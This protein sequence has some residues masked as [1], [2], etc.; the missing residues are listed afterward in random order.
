MV[1]RVKEYIEKT[2]H[3][4]NSDK[5]KKYILRGRRNARYLAKIISN[6]KKINNFISFLQEHNRNNDEFF[7]VH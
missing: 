1:V 4:K 5:S 6:K 7:N 2:K 3:I